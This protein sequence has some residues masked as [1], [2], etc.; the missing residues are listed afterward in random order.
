MSQT[1]EFDPAAHKDTAFGATDKADR[2]DV[3]IVQINDGG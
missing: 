3:V 1:H 2:E